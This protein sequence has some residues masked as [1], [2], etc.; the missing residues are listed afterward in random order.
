MF[1]SQKISIKY[2]STRS[3]QVQNLNGVWKFP[4]SG[5][6]HD[7]V[8]S[9]AISNFLF[10]FAA[11]FT[12]LCLQLFTGVNNTGDKLSP[13][14]LTPMN[15]SCP[16]FSLISFT[17]LAIINHWLTTKTPGLINCRECNTGDN[18]SLV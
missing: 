13:V 2:D 12:T 14:S 15:R 3:V 10:I 18:L 6:H 11:L 5:F 16:L 8:S 7:S 9:G 17:T 4:T 1:S